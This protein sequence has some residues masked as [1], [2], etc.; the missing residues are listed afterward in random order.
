LP[1][2]SWKPGCFLPCPSN[3]V[4]ALANGAMRGAGQAGSLSVFPCPSNIVT[5]LANRAMQ[6][7]NQARQ[8]VSGVSNRSQA[9]LPGATTGGSWQL[10]LAPG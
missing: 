6:G 9:H 10:G 8:L 7:L 1:E 3:V 5:A 4:T 2:A